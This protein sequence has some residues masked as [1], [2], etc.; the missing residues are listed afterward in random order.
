[1]KSSYRSS[2]LSFLL[3]LTI[4]FSPLVTIAQVV[5]E[6][7]ETPTVEVEVEAPAED[8]QEEVVVEEIIETEIVS[9][10]EETVVEE[11][12]IPTTEEE[13][14]D[15]VSDFVEQVVDDLVN[16]ILEEEIE[17]QPIEMQLVTPTSE[18]ITFV[19]KVE[20][21]VTYKFASN[22]EVQVTFTKLP[23][24]AGSLSIEEVL[25][26]EEQM[27]EFGALSNVAY[28][29]TS[30]MANGTFE[31]DLKLPLPEGVEDISKVVYA[32][33][34][35]DLNVDSTSVES[36]QIEVV[37]DSVVVSDLDHFTIFVI[38]P[39]DIV[40]RT[41]IP[42]NPFIEG[43][44]TETTGNADIE[45]VS[46][47]SAGIPSANGSS[48]VIKMD[49]TGGA[50]VNRAFLGY[51][52]TGLKLNEIE[53]IKW[54]TYSKV[55]TDT[56]LNIYLRKNWNETAS[57]VFAP[58]TTPN[59]WVENSLTGAGSI[60]VRHNKLIGADTQ[61]TY[62]TSAFNELMSSQYATW[63]LMVDTSARA[64]IAIISG[65]TNPTAAQ[66]HYIDAITFNTTDGD[67]YFDFENL[68]PESPVVSFEAPTPAENSYVKGTI[69]GHVVATDNEGMGSYYIR[70]WKDAF[71]SGL[72]N[73]VHNVCY[74]APGADLLGASLDKNCVYDTKTNPDGI[75]V[76]SAQFLDSDTQWGSALRTFTVD[77][78]KP[79]INF[80]NLPV[81]TTFN[82]DSI[83]FEFSATDNFELKRIVGNIYKVGV[84]GVFKS[85]QKSIVGDTGSFTIDISTLTDGDYYIKYNSEDEAGNIATTGT[86]NFTIDNTAP[87]AP[88]HETPVDN[89][90]QNINN[91][92]FEWTDSI[93]AVEYEFQSSQNPSTDGNGVLDSGVWNNKLN[94]SGDQL[95]LG[96]SRIHSVGANGVWYWQVRAIDEAGNKSD[97]TDAWK[98]TIDMVAPTVPSVTSPI[99]EQTFETTPILNEWTT[100]TDA[101]NITYQIAY[102]Y[103]D[104]HTFGGS[105]CSDVSEIDGKFVSG[106]R[107]TTNTSRNHSPSLEEQGGVTIWVRAIDEAGNKSDWS[108]GV[109]YYYDT[110]PEEP[111]VVEKTESTVVVK[112]NTAS[113][114]NELGWMFNRD[115]STD[116]PFEFNEDAAT[117]GDGSLYVLPIGNS[118]SSDKFVAEYFP[119]M[120]IS[121]LTSLTFDFKTGAES[122]ETD[123]QH[124]Y[125]NVYANFG[126]S[127]DNKF[128]D[129]RYNVVATSGSGDFFESVTFD[130]TLPYTVTT[131]TSP[132]FESPFACPAIPA[133]MDTLSPGSNIRAFAINLGDTSLND[134]GV[135]AYFDTV[136]L[137]TDTAI[138]TFDFEPTVVEVIP[139][140]DEETPEPQVEAQQSRQSSRRSGGGGSV[141]GA[142]TSGEGE[143][144]GATTEMCPVLYLTDYMKEGDANNPEQVTKLQTFL[145]TEGFIVELTGFFGPKTTE[146]VKGFQSKYAAEILQPWVDAGHVTELLPTGFVYKT[147]R[148][149]INNLSCDGAEVKPVL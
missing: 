140:E 81:V 48:H 40:E 41:L 24:I 16:P 149:K 22:D 62:S 71:E 43:W 7:I 34:V 6:V 112:E 143:V 101:T 9:E 47:V 31:Y 42:F 76:F 23:E 135:S 60:T 120:L 93:D 66:E 8:S 108:E 116:T 26:T 64:G 106:C 96:D 61:V 37:N 11:V 117:T 114:E 10:E 20:L 137:E 89:A 98:I 115:T 145:N 73:L 83:D 87:D 39:D 146:A 38:V 51:Y 15:L 104:E 54:K 82:S 102:G 52:E 44:S 2:F 68:L 45:L 21:G 138:T 91:F 92:Y 113:A 19:E 139:D 67:Q 79:V 27:S 107:D 36:T 56:Y 126:V 17:I 123:Y 25:L 3:I 29:I 111:E 49:R 144:L 4:V 133:D 130:P 94:G 147:T 127:D 33:N 46:A 50:G 109:H 1:M 129:C 99:A 70:V 80:D 12:I 13:P 55:G 84:A 32:E 78:T 97:W 88:V 132:G 85:N 30:D 53:E 121:D 86:F 136:I 148:A 105:T 28:D 18:S 65:S 14:V 35:E 69:T 63:D 103:D 125:L 5:D 72:P 119:Q 141:L 131:R 77:N 122:E 90:F 100:S 110:T 124:V 118:N 57:V 74:E 142:F 134:E 128:Y 75:Y 95:F 59:T 58:A